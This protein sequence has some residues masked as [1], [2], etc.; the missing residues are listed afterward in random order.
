[1]DLR[2]TRIFA[3]AWR[4]ARLYTGAL[5]GHARRWRSDVIESWAG[6]DPNP[7]SKLWAVYSHFNR[8]G[9][10]FD[11]TTYAIRSLCEAG[12]RIVFVTNAKNFDPAQ[13]PLLNPF[14]AKI[15]KR[16]NAGYDFGAYKEGINS[17]PDLATMDG[18][19][20]MNDSVYGPLFPL[21]NTLDRMSAIEVD[22]WGLTDSWQHAYHLQSYFMYFAKR[23]IGSSD[24]HKFWRSIPLINYKRG[25]IEYLEIG[26]SQFLL[27]R[28]YRLSAAFPYYSLVDRYLALLDKAPLDNIVPDKDARKIQEGLR[29]LLQMGRFVN[30][31]H[32]FW[33]ILINEFQ[34]PFIKNELLSPNPDHIYGINSWRD[35]VM[36]CTKYDINLI[37]EHQK[38]SNRRR[39]PSLLPNIRS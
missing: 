26:L 5:I 15:V 17:I 7:D 34:Y 10:I 27:Q 33:D 35:T 2:D 9:Q 20:L 8:R 25:V 12:F 21:K 30:P 19:V 16:R 36:T 4:I 23:L 6:D 14:C 24:F 29:T 37:I 32:Y 28:G 31:T 13:L 38:H 3:S 22:F 11:F 39:W 18:L 1:M